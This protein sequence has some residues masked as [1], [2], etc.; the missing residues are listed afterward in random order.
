MSSRA[1]DRTSDPDS[2][3]RPGA[4]SGK[5]TARVFFALWP[6]GQVRQQLDQ[7]AIALHKGC[8]GRKTKAET[9]HLTLV[10]LGEVEMER[11]DRLR[12]A[13]AAIDG[14]RFCLEIDRLG[15]W[16]H[17]RIAWAGS[18]QCPAELQNLVNA[19]EDGLS[20]EGLRF[21]RRPYSPHLTLVRKALCREAV[22]LPET[23]R[24]EVSEF[25]L[26]QSALASSGSVYTVIGRW[27][28]G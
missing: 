19:L 2:A 17:N 28:L 3:G 24:W 13:A 15:Y 25:V 11:L 7:A 16:K 27:P 6:D 4:P 20:G 12:S 21:D 8:G 14:R 18:G 5:S 23:I 22:R 26:V 9:I 1:S 10:F